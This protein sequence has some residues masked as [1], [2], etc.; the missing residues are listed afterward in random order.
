MITGKTKTGF[1]YTISEQRLNNYELIEAIGEVEEYPL[2][3]TKVVNLLLGKDLAKELKEH[4]RDDEGFV[5]SEKLMEEIM[6]IFQGQ[7]QTKN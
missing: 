7:S 1:V 6:D 3:I 2:A 5:S 4:I